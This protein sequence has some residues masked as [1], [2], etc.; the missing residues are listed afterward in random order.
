ML[1]WLT[2]VH[3]QDILR[4]VPC[5]DLVEI[6]FERSNLSRTETFWQLQYDFFLGKKRK[7][8]FLRVKSHK[9]LSAV[10]STSLQERNK[11]LQGWNFENFRFPSCNMHHDSR[12]LGVYVIC[13]AINH[14][15]SSL[16]VWYPNCRLHFFQRSQ[17]S[18]AMHLLF[19][20]F[21]LVTSSVT[22]ITAERLR[23]DIHA[24]SEKA[25]LT[26]I[27]KLL[28]SSSS[29]QKK[30]SPMKLT[31][32]WNASS[33]IRA[34]MDVKEEESLE[35]YTV[36]IRY[37]DAT[38]TTVAVAEATHLNKCLPS[39]VKSGAYEMMTAKPETVF[40]GAAYRTATF[41]D[42][43]CL[44]LSKEGE[45]TFYSP[46]C[47]LE[48]NIYAGSYLSSTGFAI[49]MASTMIAK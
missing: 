30:H 16:C 10:C 6:N 32:D 26:T 38:C 18:T 33:A 37:T 14:T 4:Q 42:S 28:S 40:Y 21:L 35:G 24:V 3:V 43:K 1:V 7:N 31:A 46:D 22:I 25:S 39:T 45:S 15:V 12:R 19:V 34:T 44:T 36:R 2:L 11:V 5:R 41:S 13:L 17:K 20:N 49:S 29:E 48:G 47:K 8:V 9:E 27:R 23:S